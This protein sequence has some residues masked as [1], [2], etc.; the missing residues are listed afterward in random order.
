MW[1]AAFNTTFLLG[2]LLIELLLS[3]SPPIPRLLEAINTNGLAIFLVANLLTGLVNLSMRTM[4]MDDMKSMGVLIG[5]SGLVC[6]IAWVGRAV[7]L[8]I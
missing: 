1:T 5:Y 6:A 8:K 4:Y 7:R 2:Y 3:P